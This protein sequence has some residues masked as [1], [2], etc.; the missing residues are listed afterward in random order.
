MQNIAVISRDIQ[1]SY[2]AAEFIPVRKL[3]AS[4]QDTIFYLVK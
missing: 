4:S 1:L 3:L 2:S